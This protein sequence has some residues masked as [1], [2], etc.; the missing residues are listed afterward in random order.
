MERARR[1]IGG[2]LVLEA[3]VNQTAAKAEGFRTGARD[4]ANAAAPRG[5]TAQRSSET[6][7]EALARDDRWNQS[8]I[9]A[10]RDTPTTDECYGF[11]MACRDGIKAFPIDDVPL[12][13]RQDYALPSFLDPHLRMLPFSTRVGPPTTTPVA[14]PEPQRPLPS[15]VRMPNSVEEVCVDGLYKERVEPWM[16]HM[17]AWLNGTRTDPPSTCVIGLAGIKPEYRGFWFT[18][19]EG[20]GR[21]TA[22]ADKVVTHL[23]VPTLLKYAPGYPNQALFT[24]LEYGVDFQTSGLEQMLVLQAHG[25]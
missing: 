21:L 10:L 15:N 14:T 9:T 22:F 4:M 17:G 12:A 7:A 8:Y 1:Y 2:R 18:F 24:T 13:F 23:I 3:S 11:L 25:A 16:A 20:V 19:E 5:A 6:F